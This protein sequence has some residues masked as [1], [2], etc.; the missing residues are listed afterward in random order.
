[1]ASLPSSCG[2]E[3]NILAAYEGPYQIRPAVGNRE[4]LPLYDRHVMKNELPEFVSLKTIVPLSTK[5]VFV[6][7]VAFVSLPE[8]SN[9]ESSGIVNVAAL[10]EL[11]ITPS[12]TVR[13]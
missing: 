2:R 11:L 12:S 3:E 5:F 1:L 9:S 10:E 4:I 6:A 7:V 8:N 13:L